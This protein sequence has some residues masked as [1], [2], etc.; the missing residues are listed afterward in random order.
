MYSLTGMHPVAACF[1]FPV[2]VVLYTIFGGLRATFLTDFLHTIIVLLLVIT[3][4]LTVYATSDK[5]GSTHRV[6][7]LLVEAARR[8]P[9]EGNAEGSYLTMRSHQGIIFFVIN[10]VG[11]F[12]TVFCDTGYYQKAIAAGPANSL[13]GYIIGGLSWFAIPWVCAT[14]MGLAALALEKD[15]DFPFPNGIPEAQISAGLVLPYAAVTL[16]GTGGAAACLLY[17]HKSTSFADLSLVFMAVTSAMSSELIAIS[18][19]WTYDIYRGYLR[20]HSTIK[21]NIFQARVSVVVFALFMAGFSSGLYYIGISMNYLYLLMG[22]LVSSAVA[23][24]TLTLMWKKMNKYAATMSPIMGF[25]VAVGSW[26]GTAKQQYGVLTRESTGAKI[27]MLVGNLVALLSPVI[28]V[29]IFTY[30]AKPEL[31]PESIPQ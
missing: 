14:T 15:A 2:G 17:G 8:H 9:V 28:F 22:V 21:D 1:L 4:A 26:L 20:P 6:F 12:G 23:P 19:L 24:I 11:N 5:L 10:I 3:F 31:L 16:L 13:A 18:S 27:P 25:A 7:D 29:G 30:I